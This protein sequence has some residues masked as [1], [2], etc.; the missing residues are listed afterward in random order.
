MGP[1]IKK[2]VKSCP[3]CQRVKINKHIKPGSFPSKKTRFKSV[4]INIFGPLPE[5][6]SH[7]HIL[8]VID[9]ASGYPIPVL[10]WST[11]TAEV[12]KAFANH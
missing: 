3:V 10:L 9:W 2:F 6:S 11:E 12:W 8:T 5:S 7:K 1:N 4:H